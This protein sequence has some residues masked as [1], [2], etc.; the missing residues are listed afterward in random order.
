MLAQYLENI[1]GE[2]LSTL[3]GEDWKIAKIETEKFC[4]FLINRSLN[5]QQKIKGPKHDMH[6]LF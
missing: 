6:K 4:L 5:V 3:T 1:T 2:Y